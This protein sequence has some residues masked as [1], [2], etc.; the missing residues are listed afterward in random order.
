MKRIRLFV[1]LIIVLLLTGCSYP[2][3]TNRYPSWNTNGILESYTLSDGR[4]VDG[5]LGAKVGEVV[6]AKWYDFVVN[7]VEIAN[8]YAGYTAS[9]GKTLIHSSITITNTSDKIVYLF[10]GDF[11]LM[12]NLE[13]N[14]R[15]YVYSMDPYFS[16]MLVQDMSINI[17]ESK[18]IHTVYE[19]DKKIINKKT[20]AIYYH[21]Q[22]SDGQ[23]GNNYYV[24]IN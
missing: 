4:V 21:E 9:D 17:G 11:L 23:K 12:W 5:W 10:D 20:M 7:Y 1:L 24:Y 8:S 14:E 16:D 19:V 22:Y 13:K 2:F 15:D 18:T 3:Q 6:K